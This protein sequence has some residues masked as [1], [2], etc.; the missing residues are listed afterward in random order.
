MNT[1]QPT[2]SQDQIGQ[3]ESHDVFTHEAYGLITMTT[4]TGGND[5]LF[6]SDIKHNQRIS[7]SISRAKLDR[8]NSRDWIHQD[9]GLPMVE[10]EMSHAQFA[11]FI[12]SNGNG[13]GTPITLRYA[14]APG[15]A[16]ACMAGIAN[17]ETKA[18]TLRREIRDSA[19][20]Q[21]ENIAEMVNSFGALLEA[22]KIG[23]KEARAI[24][25]NMSIALENLPRNL[26]FTVEQGERAI[27]NAQSA[28]LI[29][30]EAFTSMK[31]N[32][33]GLK[34]IEE[35]SDLGA[36]QKTLDNS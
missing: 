31:L 11:Q 22:G 9:G 2:K 12:T 1:T 16:S 6:G 7:I 4:P 35:F 17:I 19:K 36:K 13:N 21:I 23:I 28:A 34:S 8:R 30:V 15:T 14:P 5:T 32:Q 3:C 27:A 10:F 33:L 24:H 29:E 26:E 25:R 20:S 18:E